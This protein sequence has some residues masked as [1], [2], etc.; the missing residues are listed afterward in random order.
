MMCKI[1]IADC[2][3]S[4][5]YVELVVMMEMGMVEWAMEDIPVEGAME[6]TIQV[7]V[8]EVMVVAEVVEGI[9]HTVGRTSRVFGRD[10]TVCYF[11]SRGF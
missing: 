3:L 9:I 4:E 8:L 5:Y 6:A 10:N 2:C 1:R 7:E 11:N